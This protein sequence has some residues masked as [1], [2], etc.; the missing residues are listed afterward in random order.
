MTIECPQQSLHTPEPM[1]YL[2]WHAYAERMAADKVQEPC[3][4]LCG[5]LIWV[6]TDDLCGDCG[7]PTAHHEGPGSPCLLEECECARW[8]GG[9]PT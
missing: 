2:E 3:T 7:H 5:K 4:G 9:E 1:G 8:S 6:S